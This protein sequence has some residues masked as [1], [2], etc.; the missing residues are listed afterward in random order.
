MTNQITVGAIVIISVVA[1][2]MLGLES[3]EILVAAVSGL[4]GYLTGSSN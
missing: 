2:F 4:I 3:K 1:A